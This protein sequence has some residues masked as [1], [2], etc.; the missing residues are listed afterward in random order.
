MVE[1]V[2]KGVSITTGNDTLLFL[3]DLLLMLLMSRTYSTI[4]FYY[5][6]SSAVHV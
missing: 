3:V 6:V 5:H 1:G 4:L 2:W